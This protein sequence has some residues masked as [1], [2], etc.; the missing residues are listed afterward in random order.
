MKEARERV[1]AAVKNC[2]AKY[3]VSRITVNL[4]PAAQRKEGTVYDLPI[5]LGILAASE[6]AA[7]PSGRR[8]LH[9]GAASLPDELRPVSGCAAHGHGGS[10]GWVYSQLYVPAENAAEATLAQGL[11][12]YP[13]E[14]VEQLC[15][16]SAGAGS[17]LPRPS[18]AASAPG[19]AAAAGFCRCQ[20]AGDGEA[21]SGDR[22]RRRTQHAADRLSRV[23]QVHAGQ[24]VCPPFSRT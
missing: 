19:A 10:A 1:R 23:R 9:R 4:A 6:A 3:P 13:V 14:T 18:L 15:G 11:T 2:G 7:A 21:G 12:V 16:P 22:R 17:P 8:G 5:F 20:G 24:G